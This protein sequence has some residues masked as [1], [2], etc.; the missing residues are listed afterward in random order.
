MILSIIITNYV[1]LKAVCVADS[2]SDPLKDYS[3]YKAFPK[4]END[5]KL[6]I[7]LERKYGVDLWS[8]PNRLLRPVLF[9]V[10][11]ES[12]QSVVKHLTEKRIDI[13]LITNDLKKLVDNEREEISKISES[14]AADEVANFEAYHNYEKIAFIL[15]EWKKKYPQNVKTRVIGVTWEKRSIY[16]LKITGGKEGNKPIIFFEC[17]IHAREWISPTTCLYF[18]NTL[19]T[20]KSNQDTLLNKYDFHF[21]PVLNADGYA[22]TWTKKRD[23]RRNRFPGTI[24]H[25]AC[26]GVDLNRNFDPE[27][28]KEGST[29][30]LCLPSYCGTK[31][32]SENETIA[33]RDYVKELT[34]NQ[35]MK[36]YFA[37][38]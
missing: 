9:T 34:K 26:I 15:E 2:N 8:E 1:L 37:M 38:H 3:L 12:R 36:I 11:P 20:N 13:T 29:K 7:S 6:L 30:N 19:L 18:A 16:A 27:H 14:F 25:G 21:V 5:L 28:C 24:G 33:I 22:Y 4:N 32:F 23:W 31:A 10:S 17:G 35:T